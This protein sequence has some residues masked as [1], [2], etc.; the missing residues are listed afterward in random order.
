MPRSNALALS[1]KNQRRATAIIPALNQAKK[2]T[3]AAL[4]HRAVW[5]LSAGS[6]KQS[7]LSQGPPGL[8]NPYGYGPSNSR[9]PRG[10]VPYGN[11]AIINRQSDD[12]AASWDTVG[13][14]TTNSVTVLIFNTSPHAKF[15]L[16]TDRMKRRPVLEELHRLEDAPFSRRVASAI[17]K[18][19]SNP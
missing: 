3:E 16:G 5:E 11:L 8:N 7:T 19:I 2:D 1:K 6:V 12:F 17:R 14:V 18:A 13:L 10:A 15:L 9:G 4:W